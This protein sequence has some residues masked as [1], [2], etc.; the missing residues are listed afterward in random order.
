MARTTY[1]RVVVALFHK[2]LTIARLFSSRAPGRELPLCVSD[3]LLDRRLSFNEG[4]AFI[5]HTLEKEKELPLRTVEVPCW[6]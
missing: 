1:Q 5:L 3:W 4:L 2:A 6:L